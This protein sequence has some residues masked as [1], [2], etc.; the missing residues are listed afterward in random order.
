MY[1]SVVSYLLTVQAADPSHQVTAEV[2][3]TVIVCCFIVYYDSHYVCL[4]KQYL[5]PIHNLVF[6]I[7]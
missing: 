4:Y 5:L 1:V 2:N 6:H 3:I 7:C